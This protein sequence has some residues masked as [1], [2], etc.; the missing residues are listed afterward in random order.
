MGGKS[1][2]VF[3]KKA[4]ESLHHSSG[5]SKS[6]YSFGGFKTYV[7]F[8]LGAYISTESSFFSYKAKGICSIRKTKC[9]EAI[10]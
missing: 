7:T 2:S 5:T 8:A 6:W 10:K 4:E 1:P 9:F 3:D